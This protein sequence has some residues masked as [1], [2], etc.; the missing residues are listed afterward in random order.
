MPKY[1]KHLPLT[2]RIARPA[3]PPWAVILA[4]ITCLLIAACD[5]SETTPNNPRWEAD[6]PTVSGQNHGENSGNRP[7]VLK[8][9][10]NRQ[11]VVNEA[12]NLSLEALDPDADPLTFAVFGDL[13][14]NAKFDKL[15]GRL[16]WTPKSII[17]PFYLTFQVSDG[18]EIDRETV[19]INTTNQKENE[20]PSFVK[21]GDQV[22]PPGAQMALT[23]EATDP[24]SD[25]LLFEIDGEAPEGTSL[26]AESGLFQWNVPVELNGSTIRIGFKV[27]DGALSDT[28]DTKFIIGDGAGV[29]SP[30]VFAPIGPFDAA[31]L[32]PAESPP[33]SGAD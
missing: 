30:P 23:L 8:R 15:E 26:D 25:K 31:D 14:A 7:P 11:V 16:D 18:I 19:R 6:I 2:A 24:N 32:A 22:V 1:I 20:A 28:M 21:I 13:P 29:P 27:T 9:I 4:S 5:T 33:G 10:G 3:S 17:A 12:L